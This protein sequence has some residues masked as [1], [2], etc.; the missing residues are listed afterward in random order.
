MSVPIKL[1]SM[2]SIKDCF[3]EK[4]DYQMDSIPICLRITKDR[5]LNYLNT[6]INT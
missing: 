2:S 3:T 4:K 1:N 6:F 5:K